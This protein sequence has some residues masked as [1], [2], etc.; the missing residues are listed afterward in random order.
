[1]PV[2]WCFRGCAASLGSVGLSGL[3]TLRWALLDPLTTALCGL[4]R[5]IAP[6]PTASTG[7]NLVGVHPTG[8]QRPGMFLRRLRQLLRLL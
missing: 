2:K 3:P 5:S 4:G 1:M 7:K 8:P 6:P